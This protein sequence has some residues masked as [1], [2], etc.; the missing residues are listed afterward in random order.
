MDAS[1]AGEHVSRTMS[2]VRSRSYRASRSPGCDRTCCTLSEECCEINGDGTV[3][4]GPGAIPA[5]VEAQGTGDHE[6]DRR[7]EDEA[8]GEHILLAQSE[9]GTAV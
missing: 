3:L 5:Q 7:R 1:G 9:V 4:S 8:E 2:G 6:V